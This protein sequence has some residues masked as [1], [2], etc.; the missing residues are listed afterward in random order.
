MKTPWPNR[1]V[2]AAYRL[3]TTL[4]PGL[5]ESV[6][7]AARLSAGSFGARTLADGSKSC[8]PESPLTNA[9]LWSRGRV[10]GIGLNACPTIAGKGTC[11]GGGGGFAGAF[12]CGLRAAQEG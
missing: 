9:E 1:R 11:V 12:V 7:E 2:D 5:L 10:C 8:L 3:H 4:G 6:Y